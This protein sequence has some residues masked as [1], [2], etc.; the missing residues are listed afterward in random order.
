MKEDIHMIKQIDLGGDH[1]SMGLQHGLQVKE[2][3]PR[4]LRVVQNRLTILQDKDLDFRSILDELYA[5]WEENARSTLEMMHGIADALELE[6][7]DFF[8]YTVS[9]YLMDK[10]RQQ[11]DVFQGCSVWAAAPPLTRHVGP[12]LA[13]NRDYWSDHTDLQCFARAHP[14]GGY[15]YAYLTSAGSPGVFSSGMNEAGLAVADTHVVSQDIGPGLP[16]YAVMM[17]ILEHYEQVETALEYILSVRHTGNGTIVLVDTSGG[18]GVVE[19]GYEVQVVRHPENSFVVSTNHFVS[20]DLENKVVERSAGKAQYENSLGRYACMKTNLY[21]LR[22]PVD[23]KWAKK[24]LS[25]HGSKEKAICRHPEDNP[26]YVTISS[27]IFLPQSR[28]IQLAAGMPCQTP[29]EPFSVVSDDQ[30]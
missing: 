21:T 9:T 2:L 12:I 1:Y 7:D 28:T 15:R 24:M 6:W 17:D 11:Y 20:P 13:K 27:V 3:R 5:V 25:S 8:R 16:R 22:E 4:I 30:N 18:M 29:Y 26:R 10:V 23:L 14:H 19:T